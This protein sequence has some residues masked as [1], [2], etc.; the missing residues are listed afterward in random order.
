MRYGFVKIV[1]FN[2]NKDQVII[3]KDKCNSLLFKKK[4]QVYIIVIYNVHNI[5]S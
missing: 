1:I 3:K 4:M 5:I 2:Y